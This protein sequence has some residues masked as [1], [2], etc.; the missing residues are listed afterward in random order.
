M[1][2]MKLLIMGAPG[3]GKGTQAEYI[4]EKLDIPTISTGAMLRDAITS[5][6]GLGVVAKQFIDKGNLVTDE[7][8]IGIVVE[9]LSEA[10]C[11]KG[12]ILDGFP[13]TLKQ[14]EAMDDKGLQVD[15]ALLIKVDDS[16][17]IDRIGGRRVCKDCGETYHIQFKPPASPDE[18]DI[19][20]GELYVRDD[21]NPSTVRRRLEAYHKLTEPVIDYYRGLGKLITIDGHGSVTDVSHRVLS[22]LGVS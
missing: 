21:D 5:G 17:I 1:G 14:A 18:C 22:E 3:S 15:V 2:H 11:K 16:H 20:G 19:C 8:V 9:R 7:I 13:R 4:S 12:F 6:T 10:D